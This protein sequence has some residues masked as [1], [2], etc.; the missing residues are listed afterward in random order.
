MWSDPWPLS[1]DDIAELF[2]IAASAVGVGEWRTER[3]GQ[4]G[5]FHVE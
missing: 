2:E 5:L 1:P 3:G 4:F